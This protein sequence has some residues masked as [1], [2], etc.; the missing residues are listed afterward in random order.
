MILDVFHLDISGNDGNEEQKIN[1]ELI[2]VTLDVFHLDISGND[3]ID[4]ELKIK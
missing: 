2:S 4:E 1:I 3:F